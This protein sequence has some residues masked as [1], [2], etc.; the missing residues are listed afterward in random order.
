MIS[1][2]TTI[3]V[4]LAV[5]IL[6]II[7]YYHNTKIASLKHICHSR[8]ACITPIEAHAK[9]IEDENM[10]PFSMPFKTNNKQQCIG[11]N[12][13]SQERN[14]E[15]METAEV[16]VIAENVSDVCTEFVSGRIINASFNIHEIINK[17][18][19]KNTNRAFNATD[20]MLMNN[21]RDSL[22]M[23][24]IYGTDDM[25]LDSVIDMNLNT[26]RRHL[27]AFGLGIEE[28]SKD[29]DCAF[30]SIIKQLHALETTNS[31]LTNHLHTLDLLKSE[32][33]DTYKLRQLFVE[34]IKKEDDEFISF[35]PYQASETVQRKAE[36]FRSAGVFDKTIG[37]LTIK[38][39]AHVL[40]VPI[41][42]ITSNK[43]VPYMPF[44]PNLIS[45][46]ESIYIAFHY[47]GA[48]HYDS[49]KLLQG[50][51]VSFFTQL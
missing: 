27:A 5:A 1:G 46:K 33:E 14:D 13:N 34:E 26:L 25:M 40:Q 30:R 28:V 9:D 17:I 10:P 32:D 2:A 38:I 7:F 6:T 48:G 51:Q 49:T 19:G 12:M 36:E 24:N 47:Y 3:S 50:K 45:T 22:N 42:V 41:I 4:E 21:M 20:I 18:R 11:V 8:V 35:L 44:I 43:S 31:G 15:E 16:L 39:C 23:H 29:G 37:D